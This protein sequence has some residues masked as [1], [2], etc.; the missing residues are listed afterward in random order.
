VCVFVA[1]KIYFFSIFLSASVPAPTLKMLQL[2]LKLSIDFF[3]YQQSLESNNHQLRVDLSQVLLVDFE[4]VVI[5]SVQ[6]GSVLVTSTVTA[7]SP[8]VFYPTATATPDINSNSNNAPLA[9]SL[10]QQDS[11]LAQLQLNLNAAVAN[12]SSGLYTG[13]LTSSLVTGSITVTP[14]T[15][16]VCPN[17][18]V[19]ATTGTGTGTGTCPITGTAAP[20]TSTDGQA[21]SITIIIVVIAVVCACV[22]VRVCL[23]VLAQCGLPSQT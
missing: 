16:V 22:C 17:G 10:A 6:A 23:Y 8:A 13:Q 21:D 7:I 20:N 4:L 11:L 19:L 1:I 18:A 5:Q 3:L 9:P 15:A 2:S 12:P 14:K